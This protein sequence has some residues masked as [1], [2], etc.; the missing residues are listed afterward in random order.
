MELKYCP[1]EPLEIKKYFKENNTSKEL[2]QNLAVKGCRFTL[3]LTIFQEGRKI[4]SI[5]HNFLW[6]YHNAWCLIV[7]L[8]SLMGPWKKLRCI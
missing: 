3:S 8:F 1:N 6:V 5:V 7:Q 4:I 2:F